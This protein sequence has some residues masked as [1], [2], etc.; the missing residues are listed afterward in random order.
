MWWLATLL[1]KSLPYR[2]F[3]VDSCKISKSAFLTEQF[4]M[5]ASVHYQFHFIQG[6]K[7]CECYK[8]KKIQESNFVVWKWNTK[9]LLLFFSIFSVFIIFHL[10]IL[11]SII[12]RATMRQ[13]TN[14]N[15]TNICDRDLNTGELLNMSGFWMRQG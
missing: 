13:T 2:C 11:L 3:L 6:H 12:F 4:G 8:F 14:T 1:K 7:G 5:T 10:H 9:F 15:N